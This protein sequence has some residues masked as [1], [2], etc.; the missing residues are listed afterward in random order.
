[1]PG[2]PPLHCLVTMTKPA[3][4][5]HHADTADLMEKQQERS[6]HRDCLMVAR[7]SPADIRK[8]LTLLWGQNRGQRD[9][10]EVILAAGQPLSAVHCLKTPW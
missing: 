7:F 8:V 10:K 5:K 2:F 9:L 6:S 4:F 3:F 1:M